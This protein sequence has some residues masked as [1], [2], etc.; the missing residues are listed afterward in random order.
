[1]D[2]TS[3]N[4]SFSADVKDIKTKKAQTH[5]EFEAL[6]W[7]TMLKQLHN[8]GIDDGSKS[9]AEKMY[10]NLLQQEYS[11]T[12]AAKTPLFSQ[13]QVLSEPHVIEK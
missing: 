4:T 5:V 9:N 12:L 11:L 2:I 8:S 1:M 10:A 3:L 7:Q 6:L 13:Q